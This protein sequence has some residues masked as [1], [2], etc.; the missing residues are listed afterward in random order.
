[1]RFTLEIKGT[2]GNKVVTR[3]PSNIV[4]EPFSLQ[5]TEEEGIYSLQKNEKCVFSGLIREI[6]D[7]GDRF[8]I[9]IKNQDFCRHYDKKTLSMISYTDASGCKFCLIETS[10]DMKSNDELGITKI[11]SQYMGSYSKANNTEIKPKKY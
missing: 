8:E 1:M 2:G 4:K 9:W 10:T 3:K 7:Y 11:N 6:T 5:K